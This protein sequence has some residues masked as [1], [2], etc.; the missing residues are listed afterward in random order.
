MRARHFYERRGFRAIEFRD[1]GASE[2]RFPDV[3]D[4][5]AAA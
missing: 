5:L 4:E 3:R 2:E 1:G